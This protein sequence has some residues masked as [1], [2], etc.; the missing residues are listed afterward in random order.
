[1]LLVMKDEAEGTLNDEKNDF[2][3][4]NAYGDETLK[5]L[6]VAVIMMARIRPTDENTETKPKYD[7]KA[8]SEVNASHIDRISGMISKVKHA[9]NAHNQTLDIES[10]V[11]NVQREPENQ[12]ILNI[13][14]NKQ[15]ELLQKELETCKERVKTLEFKS[16]QCVE[17]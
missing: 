14:L 16:A 17:N 11:Y 10:L 15:K 2:M 1:M 6:T 5:E 8:I 7:A 3:L 9:S 13:K 4:D 12:Q